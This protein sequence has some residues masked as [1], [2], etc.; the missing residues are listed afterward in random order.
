VHT[1]TRLE[2]NILI[3][4]YTRYKI[5]ET[6]HPDSPPNAIRLSLQLLHKLLGQETSITLTGSLSGGESTSVTV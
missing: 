5:D 2:E 6:A 1:A 3:V 4:E